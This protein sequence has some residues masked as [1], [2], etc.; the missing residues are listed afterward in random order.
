MS[1]DAPGAGGMPPGFPGMGMP[2][3]M[4]LEALQAMMQVGR[5]HWRLRAPGPPVA[6]AVEPGRLYEAD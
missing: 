1:G 3:G 6:A 4:N 5:G 2:G